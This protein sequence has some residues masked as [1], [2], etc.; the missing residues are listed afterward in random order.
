M[1][2]QE[3]I[4]NIPMEHMKNVFGQFDNYLKKIERTLKDRKSVV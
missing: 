3:T 1:E 4:I 2:K